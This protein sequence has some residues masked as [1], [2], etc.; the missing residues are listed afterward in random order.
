[1]T[2]LLQARSRALLQEKYH[3]IRTGF[4]GHVTDMKTTLTQ[5]VSFTLMPCSCRSHAHHAV[6]M[7]I[8]LDWL[9]QSMCD[10]YKLR[11]SATLSAPRCTQH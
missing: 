9:P 1:M 11:Q 5:I 7:H 2:M 4:D 3:H 8:M 6:H 10:D